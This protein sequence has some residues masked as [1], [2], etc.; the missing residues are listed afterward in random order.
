LSPS[1]D[2]E[3]AALAARLAGHRLLLCNGLLGEVIAGLHMDYMSTQ[4]GWL[5]DLGL[6]V[7]RAPTPTAAPIAENAARIAAII[8]GDDA[9]AI[10][11]GHS[12]GG[13]EALSA[14]LMPGIA[15]RC[16]GFLALQSPFHGSPVA[17]AALGYGPL[18]DLAHHALRLARLGDGQGLADLTCAVREP[19]MAAHESE[20]AA[21]AARLPMAS[22]ATALSDPCPWRDRAY[23]PLARW[24]EEK[25]AGPND[26]LVPVASTRLPGARH[27]VFAG[28]HRALIAAGAGRD[29]VAF[30]RAELAALLGLAIPSPPP[31][32]P[33]PHP[34]RR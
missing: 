14:L 13:L 24:M 33:A 6:A 18:R 34:P 26:G 7:A 32:A 27:A 29:P 10:L 8:E 1:T 22:L 16:G 20:I 25:G 9:P 21:L 3:D 11:I 31:P 2:P 12:K 5:R 17:D 30:L 19:W 4:L 28:G 15:E 23:L